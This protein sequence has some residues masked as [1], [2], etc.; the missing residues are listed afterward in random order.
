MRQPFL[1]IEKI[2]RVIMQGRNYSERNGNMSESVGKKDLLLSDTAVEDLFIRQYM[3]DL[4]KNAICLYLLLK[5]FSLDSFEAGFV[6]EFS[7][8]GREETELALAELVSA[9]LLTRDRKNRFV[10]V[11]LKQIEIDAYC[12]RRIAAG[13]ADLSELEMS[14]LKEERDKL[15]DAISKNIY[16]GKMGYVFYRIVDKCLN[17][18]G[19][20]SLVVYKLFETAKENKKQYLYGEVDKLAEEWNRKGYKTEEGLS[21][22]LA[23]N[24]KV[25]RITAVVGRITRKRVNEFDIER[26]TRWVETGINEDMIEYAFSR[27]ENIGVNTANADKILTTWITAGVNDLAEAQR[28]EK[29]LYAENKKK[30]ESRKRRGKMSRRS[31]VEA[32]ITVVDEKPAVDDKDDEGVVDILGIFGEED[33][34]ENDK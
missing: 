31:G 9:G 23:L 32:G 8:T 3:I 33:E 34:D 10:F 19:F 28:Y 20:D 15:C 12:A 30:Y 14:P 21:G 18:Y 5:S 25:K 4:S 27:T 26:I 7:M 29:E 6:Q 16:A 17:Q 11:D 1:F 13:G 24:E 22:Y 2:I